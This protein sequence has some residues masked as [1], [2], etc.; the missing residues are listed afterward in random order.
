MS[1]EE[2][3]R[4]TAVPIGTVKWRLHNANGRMRKEL[5]RLGWEVER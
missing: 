2:I 3:A 5:D 1:I 4:A